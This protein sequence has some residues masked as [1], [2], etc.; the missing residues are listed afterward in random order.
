LTDEAA[1]GVVSAFYEAYAARDPVAAASLYA[2][3]GIHEEVATG[4]VRTGR[5]AIAAGLAHFFAAFPD[6]TWET[7]DPYWGTDGA[8]VTY[9]LNGTLRSRFGPFEPRGQQLQLRGVHVLKLAGS[10]IARSSDYWDAGTF[11]KQMRAE[12]PAV[13]RLAARSNDGT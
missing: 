4:Q 8:A 6:A 12:Q 1:R 10:A 7:A 3:D 13:E 5:D 11:G 2:P 9:T